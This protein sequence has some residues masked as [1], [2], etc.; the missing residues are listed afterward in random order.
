[1]NLFVDRMIRAAK[2]DIHLYEEVE[3]DKSAMGQALGVVV[4]SSLAAGI[5]AISV[6]GAGGIVMGTIFALIGWFIWAF[7]TYIIGTKLLP[8]PQTRADY[9]ELLRT[10]GFSSSP[11]LIRV[12]GIIPGVQSIVFVAAGIWMLVAMVI[13]V[14]QALD[15]HSTWRAVGVCLIG[16][17]VQIL[18]LGLMLAAIGGGTPDTR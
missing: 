6:Q 5:G 1:M 12:L 7:L 17:L 4:L 15:Y 9:G 8:E 10:I 16:W 3:A 14:R 13:A 2:L 18:L 11:G